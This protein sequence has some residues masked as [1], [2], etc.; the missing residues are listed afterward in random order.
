VDERSGV[1]DSISELA[2]RMRRREV[3]PV[4]IVEGSLRRIE[5]LNPS[6]NAYTC[7]AAERAIEAARAAERA[8]A[9]EETPG[10]LCGVPLSVKDV[11]ETADAPTTW[12][13]KALA[14]YQSHRDATVVARLR[15]AGAIVLAKANV[16]MS[17]PDG[18]PDSP[19][20][21]GPTR[22]PWA[23]DR[24]AGASSGGS[25]AA[26]AARLD[27]GSIGSDTTGSIR[28]PAAWCGVIGLKPTFGLVSTHGVFPYS[29]SFDTC[30]PMARTVRDCALLL[31]AIAGADDRGTPGSGRSVPEYARSVADDARGVRVGLPR[32]AAWHDNDPDV[33]RAVDSAVGVLAALGAEVHEIALPPLD[34]ALWANVIS[35]LE[36]TD[37]VDAKLSDQVLSDRYD[38]YLW[39]RNKGGRER[40]LA[41][42]AQ[43]R[44]AAERRY[45]D[46]FQRVDVIVTPTVPTVA[47][48][49]TDTASPWQRPNE[50]FVEVLPRYT[51]PASLIGYPA[52]SVPC[53][54]SADGLP[55]GVQIIGR[56]FEETTLFKVAGAYEHATDWYTRSP[57]LSGVSR[58]GAPH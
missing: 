27:F 20:L 6:L 1:A 34:E 33:T 37:L 7:V 5:A 51:R 13:A 8:F 55:V 4:E 41:Q 10:P 17:P 30:G 22:N 3:S 44:V 38:V 18:G 53:G 16:D 14:G 9:R 50:P 12:G 45:A 11:F 40:V 57:A 49:F 25:A 46:L 52:I 35:L 29:R 43:L 47:P 56:P 19:R 58:R 28:G 54:F 2:R 21:I 26:V 24:K 42:A 39:R 48:L 32:Q 23:L 15:G 36:T 31:E